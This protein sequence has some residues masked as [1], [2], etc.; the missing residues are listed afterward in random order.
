MENEITLS[1]W[2][3][4]KDWDEITVLY[5]ERELDA[6]PF[7]ILPKLGVV[8]R[9]N[10]EIVG[11][12][13]LYMD[14][15]CSVCF[16][17]WLVTKRGLNLHIARKVAKLME[18]FITAEAFHCGYRYAYTGFATETLANEAERLGYVPIGKQ[19]V[20]LKILR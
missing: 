17:H 8:A 19:F 14:N 10:G 5:H 11:T 18:Q 20:M 13:W 3:W 15:S 9:I 1:L 7:A 16:P 4:V 2:D 12:V 6:P